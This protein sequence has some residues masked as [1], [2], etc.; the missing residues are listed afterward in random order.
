[1][2]FKINKNKEIYK[3]IT[4]INCLQ[5]DKIKSQNLL[6]QKQYN[7]LLYDCENVK[8]HTNM[9]KKAILKLANQ[10]IIKKLLTVLDDLESALLSIGNNSEFFFP[11]KKYVV[12][13]IQDGLI[14]IIKNFK[15]IFSMYGV[16][17]INALGTIFDPLKHEALRNIK[18]NN[19]ENNLII[20]EYQKGYILY[21]KLLK[22]SK[23]TVNIE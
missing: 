5:F 2:K 11:Y 13:H 12:K 10:E 7:A 6:Y 9:E 15:K 1:M 18:K 23:V 4:V 22:A 3:N 17:E 19:L 14:L 20:E 16:T 8:K 21:N